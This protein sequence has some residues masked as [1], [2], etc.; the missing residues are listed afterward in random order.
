MDLVL[1]R[2]AEAIDGYPDAGRELT[3]KGHMQAKRM[4]AWLNARL[5]DDALILASPARRAQQTAAALRRVVVT[6]PELDTAADV[7]AILQAVRWP[8]HTQT[9]VVVGHQPVLGQ[10]AS[11][12]LTGAEGD[13]SVKKG[14]A[15]W[16]TARQRSGS[17][18]AVLLAVMV[19]ELLRKD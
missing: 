18:H 4:A 15:W 12:L 5:P 3:D 16:I 13:L 19:P 11:W 6:R 8:R 17:A 2:H 9:T 14:A 1:W 10:V 7:Q